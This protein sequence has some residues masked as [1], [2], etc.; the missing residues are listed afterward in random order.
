MINQQRELEM[1]SENL[2]LWESVQKTN[3]AATKRV[4]QRGGFTAIDAYSQIMAA[5]EQFGPYGKG[6]GFKQIDLDFSLSANGLVIFKGLFFF[7]GG[8]FP[9]INSVEFSGKRIDSEFAK[10]VETDS[11]TKCLSR[12]GFNADV[13][14]GR[15]DDSRYVE[16][17]TA[18]INMKAQ[19]E[20]WRKHVEQLATRLSQCK[21]IEALQ[22]F[23]IGLNK[24]EHKALTEAKDAKKS[25]LQEEA[26]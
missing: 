24:D 2:K 8:E 14:M 7:P 22:Q 23:W 21:T 16:Q 19:E 4:S 26:A 15:F 17:I 20:A 3:P 10:K 5:T 6:W 18:E 12:L 9:M 11:I 25:E 1:S 13:F